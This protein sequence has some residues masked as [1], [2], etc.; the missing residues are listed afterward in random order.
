MHA[1]IDT[2]PIAAIATFILKSVHFDLKRGQ[3][4]NVESIPLAVPLEGD[5]S[6][7]LSV[8][9]KLRRRRQSW[10]LKQHNLDIDR[11]TMDI[12][13]RLNPGATRARRDLSA[14]SRCRISE[15]T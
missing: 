5:Q 14:T 2:P 6:S 1:C 4:G 8:Y 9:L 11:E 7:I 15:F 3:F 12:S 13:P 10:F